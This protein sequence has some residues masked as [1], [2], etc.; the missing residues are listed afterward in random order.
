M[1][2]MCMGHH[3]FDFNAEVFWAAHDCL[4]IASG[5][6]W[7]S[8][9]HGEGSLTLGCSFIAKDLQKAWMWFSREFG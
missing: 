9:F 4:T 6:S 1:H 8:P 5:R 7:A 3:G 2:C